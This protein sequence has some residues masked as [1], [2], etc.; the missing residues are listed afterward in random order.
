MEG[1]VELRMMSMNIMDSGL[2]KI[3]KQYTLNTTR[4]FLN[5]V[6]TS[7]SSLR[8]TVTGQMSKQNQSRRRLLR[9]TLFQQP[10]FSSNYSNQPL[11]LASGPVRQ[12][13][14]IKSSGGN[15]Y[16][17]DN[18]VHAIT[19]LGD[20]RGK[21]EKYKQLNDILCKKTGFTSCYPISF[22]TYT[23]KAVANYNSSKLATLRP[24]RS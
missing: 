11:S 20:L 12:L 9:I 15:D 7:S 23:G 24:L 18:L 4:K 19:F 1:K 6:L 21:Q 16:A 5:G 14:P 22:Q 17:F 2:V 13:H 8:R 10:H 3:S